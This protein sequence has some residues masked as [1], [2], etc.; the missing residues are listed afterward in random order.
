M[1]TH[2]VICEEAADGSWSARAA[3][4]PVYAVGD[5]KEEAERDIRA[6]IALYLHE[7]SASVEVAVEDT[8]GL[9]HLVP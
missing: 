6:A 4:L 3:D 5:T 9:Q 7:P 2:S 1:R 8:P